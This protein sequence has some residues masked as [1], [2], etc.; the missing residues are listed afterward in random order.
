MRK[1]NPRW[2]PRQWIL[3]SIINTAS[4]S[5]LCDPNR[6]HS[7]EPFER[8]AQL[9]IVDS[10]MRVLLF[11]TFGEIS[12]DGVAVPDGW[13][14]QEWMLVEEWSS[15]RSSQRNLMCSCSS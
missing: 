11:D 9:D 4:S 3:Q 8:D 13:G 7:S 14:I 2:V 12:E 6:S 10:A 1:V 5:P 15:N